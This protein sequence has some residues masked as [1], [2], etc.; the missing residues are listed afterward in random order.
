MTIKYY[1]VTIGSQRK[2]QLE[3]LLALI[4]SRSITLKKELDIEQIQEK[5]YS[6]FRGNYHKELSRVLES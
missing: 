4:S 1:E 6:R 5:E 2:E 3:D